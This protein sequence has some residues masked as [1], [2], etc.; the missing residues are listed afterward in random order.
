MRDIHLPITITDIDIPEGRRE[1]NAAAVRRLAESIEQIGLRHPITVRERGER[2][3]L[4][5]GR[6]RMAA[7][8]K[9]GREHIPAIIVKMTNDEARLWEIAENLHRSDLTKLERDEQI[10]EWIKLT[11]RISNSQ[12]GSLRSDGRGGR[13][14]GVENAARELGIH[15]H[16]AHRAMQVASL[17]EEA[18]TAAREVGLDDNRSALLDA[19]AKPTVAEQVA[20]IHRRHTAPRVVKLAKDPI[21]GIEALESQVAALMNAWNKASLDARQEFLARIE[22]PLM[23]QRFG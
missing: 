16:D 1:L 21:S 2:Y 8:E 4:V 23:D 18:K 17:S 19:A 9:L 6:H 10:A 12:N 7:F 15:R 3:S 5:A 13:P 14:S 20:E 11:E 22:S